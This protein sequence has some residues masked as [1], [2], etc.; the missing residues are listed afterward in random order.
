MRP[1]HI[2]PSI[3]SADFARLGEQVQ[4]AEAAGAD[5]IHVDVMDG[6]FVPN[7]TMG[8]LVL[9]AVRRSTSI[10]LDVHLMTV[11]PENLLEMFAN[12]GAS[13]ISVH[14]EATPDVFRAVNRIKRLGCRAGIAVNPHTR[15][16][17][18]SELLPII[19]LVLVMTVSPGFGG[20]TL[21]EE[22]LPK[23]AELRALATDK[24][25]YD[26]E[27]H[28]D[29]G[30]NTETAAAVVQA[31]GNVLIAGSAIF[32]DKFTIAE[33]IASLRD[34]VEAASNN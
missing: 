21:I 11:E 16:E 17:A 29:G 6:R 3:L 26:L 31:G 30:V 34:A 24:K 32:S 25:N 9:D 18:L 13:S 8:P 2:S 28:A 5:R 27:L 15:A 14:Y 23:F 19:D 20:Q 22:T 33:G 7:I 12:A 10:P 1:L 4:A